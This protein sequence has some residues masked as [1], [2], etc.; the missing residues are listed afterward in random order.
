MQTQGDKVF[1]P[2][3]YKVAVAL[4]FK[5]KCIQFKSPL[6]FNFMN[7]GID[8]PFSKLWLQRLYILKNGLANRS[9]KKN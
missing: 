2:R 6:A 1:S 4:R 7:P 8:I 9:F 3:S 5:Y